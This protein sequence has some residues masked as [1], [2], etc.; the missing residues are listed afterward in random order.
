MTCISDLLSI[1]HMHYHKARNFHGQLIF[2]DF[3]DGHLSTK[4]SFTN[5]TK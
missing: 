4:I 5:I 1:E 2:V 3:A